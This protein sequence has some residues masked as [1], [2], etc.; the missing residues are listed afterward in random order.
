VGLFDRWGGE[1][2]HRARLRESGGDAVQLVIDYLKQ[3]AAG[4]LQGVGRYFAL[5]VA[6]SLAMSLGV[7]ILLLGLLR[8]LQT[9]TDTAFAGNLSWIPYLIVTVVAVGIVALCVWRIS[10]GPAARRRPG[11]EERGV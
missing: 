5:G 7:V 6:G 9:E 2:G 8:F 3:E 4:P 10:R 11:A 1:H